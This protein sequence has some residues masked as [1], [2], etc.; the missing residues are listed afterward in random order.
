MWIGW[1]GLLCA[2]IPHHLIFIYLYSNW[3]Y[4]TY[5]LSIPRTCPQR[6]NVFFLLKSVFSIMSISYW[7][8]MFK[9]CLCKQNLLFTSPKTCP[10]IYFRRN[11]ST[12]RRQ[13]FKTI[14]FVTSVTSTTTNSIMLYTIED[15]GFLLRTQ[16][17]KFKTA[18]PAH[19]WGG[20]L[21]P[22]PAFGS[23]KI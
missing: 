6:Q 1:R 3:I 4:E 22:F 2:L 13:S 7:P 18:M 16:E 17:T 10:I 23:G 20:I 11:V 19:Q 21:S 8:S 5:N 12:L 9:N 15:F 14:S